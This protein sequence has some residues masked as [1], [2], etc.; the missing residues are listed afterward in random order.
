MGRG[1]RDGNHSSPK[2]KVVQNLEQYEE[3]G[4]SDPES[5]KTKTNYTKEPN[6]EHKTTL[7]EE[8]LQIINENFVE[9][10]LDMVN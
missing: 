7:K 8:I 6:K 1:K 10:L 9:M 4:Y 2:D 5:N 3:N